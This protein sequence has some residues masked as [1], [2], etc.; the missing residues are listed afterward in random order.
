MQKSKHEIETRVTA[1]NKIL[2]V[3]K[4]E[5]ETS[6]NAVAEPTEFETTG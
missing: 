2:K 1:I 5:V 3:S 4:P 6:E